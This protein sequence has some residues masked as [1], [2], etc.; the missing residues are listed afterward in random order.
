[1]IPLNIF[2]VSIKD[3]FLIL[4]II[5]FY[6]IATIITRILKTSITEIS[7]LIIKG[8]VRLFIVSTVP[9]LLSAYSFIITTASF[10]S[11]LTTITN[12]H[13][14]GTS[15]LSL[16]AIIILSISII[17][18]IAI[19]F[20][21]SERFISPLSKE[22]EDINLNNLEKI[23]IKL[24]DIVPFILA[25]IIIYGILFLAI[26]PT[27]MTLINIILNILQV[28]IFIIIIDI[29]ASII[30]AILKENPKLINEEIYY[31]K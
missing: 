15:L 30:V 9:I 21:E 12:I 4:I 1:M 23:A 26:Y 7:K 22:I 10:V 14:I 8:L 27:N 5:T 29:I 19:L 20:I 6:I 17:L 3:I 24:L 25:I 2:N 28:Y 11:Q 18:G 13:I 31:I 16:L